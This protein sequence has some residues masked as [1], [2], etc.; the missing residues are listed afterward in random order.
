MAKE[1]VYNN[2]YHSKDCH[3]KTDTFGQKTRNLLKEK[4]KNNGQG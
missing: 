3:K 1:V 2:T 4:R